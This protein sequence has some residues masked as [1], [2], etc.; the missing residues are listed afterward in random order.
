[1]REA[2][3]RQID[4]LAPVFCADDLVP[5]RAEEDHQHLRD[6]VIV[7]NHQQPSLTHNPLRLQLSWS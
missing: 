1:M 7:L 2:G 6:V 4:P 3:A 5:I